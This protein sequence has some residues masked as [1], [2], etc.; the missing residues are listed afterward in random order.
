MRFEYRKLGLELVFLDENFSHTP[1]KPSLA[2]EKK[3]NTKE[4]FINP[5]LE[6]KP[7]M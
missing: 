5:F 6:E 7:L 1:N 3:D 2:E 4:Y